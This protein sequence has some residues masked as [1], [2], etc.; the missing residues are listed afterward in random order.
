MGGGPLELILRK[1]VVRTEVD[2]AASSGSCTLQ[3]FMLIPVHTGLT[4]RRVTRAS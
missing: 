4:R 2:I 1:Y 3:P